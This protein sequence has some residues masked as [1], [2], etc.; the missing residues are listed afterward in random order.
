MGKTTT[1]LW[2]ACLASAAQAHDRPR[3]TTR[4]VVDEAGAVAIRVDLARDDAAE[5]LGLAAGRSLDVVARSFDA[6]LPGALPE[7]IG[8][9]AGGRACPVRFTGWRPTELRGIRLEGVASCPEV[10]TLRLDW[11]APALST[12]AEVFAPD[13]THHTVALDDGRPSASVA[14]GG[15]RAASVRSFAWSGVEHIL[16]GWDHL[17]FLLALLLTVR[18]WRRVLAVVTT[19][20]VAH[21]VTLGL[22]ATGVVAIDSGVVEPVIA[23]SIAFAALLGLRGL[24][25]GALHGPERLAPALAVCFVFGLVHGLGFASMLAAQLEGAGRVLWP[26]VGFNAGVEAGQLACVALA[27]PLL[28]WSGGRRWERHLVASMLVSLVALGAGVTVDRIL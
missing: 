16:G 6:G 22:G 15:S 3:A 21:S 24:R 28:A 14:L 2:L 11:G 9:S 5:L 13:G 8:V 18:T 25:R 19:F 4:L 20:T 23:A 26:L 10:G 12:V 17:A 27:F 1:L 7:W